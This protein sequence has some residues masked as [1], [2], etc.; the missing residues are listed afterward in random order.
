M[1]SRDTGQSRVPAPPHMITGMIWNGINETHRKP[2]HQAVRAQ[3]IS[4]V[5]EE[6][7]FQPLHSCRLGPS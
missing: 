6:R 5:M 1:L 4:R 3:Q 7:A 2:T